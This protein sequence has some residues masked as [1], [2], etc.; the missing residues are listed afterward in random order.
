M[1]NAGVANV[2]TA[3]G[4]KLA[5][6]YL[7]LNTAACIMAEGTRQAYVPFTVLLRACGLLGIKSV[8][9]FY[10]RLFSETCIWSVWF[11]VIH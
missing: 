4:N 10:F 5:K 6:L 2:S 11:V 1:A 7:S 3:V 8:L 9:F